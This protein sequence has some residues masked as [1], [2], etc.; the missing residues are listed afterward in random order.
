MDLSNLD[1]YADARP[2]VERVHDHS[3]D[4]F[5]ADHT[6]RPGSA[7]R[8]ATSAQA[9]VVARITGHKQG[10]VFGAHV[11]HDLPEWVQ[12][13]TPVTLDDAQLALPRPVDGVLDLAQ[14]DFVPAGPDTLNLSGEP[15]QH[16]VLP[17]GPLR[18][19]ID[20]LDTL[21][22]FVLGGTHLIVDAS[23]A[24]TA[25]DALGA[26]ALDV[27]EPDHVVALNVDALGQAERWHHVRA[28]STTFGWFYALRGAMAWVEHLREQG[29]HLVFLAQLPT[30]GDPSALE[31]APDPGARGNPTHRDIVEAIGARVVST[32]EGRC[33][34]ILHLPLSPLV[35]QAS[36]LMDTLSF[37]DVDAQI[38]VRPDGTYAPHYSTS[39]ASFPPEDPRHL[40]RKRA[41]RAFEA[42]LAVADKLAIFGPDE[43]E[44]EELELLELAKQYEG[45]VL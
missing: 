26:R 21:T 38:V 43:C 31:V 36:I 25:L 39:K 27:L 22:P 15:P 19:G 12:P 42:S 1:D 45:V 13:G 17:Q 5:V 32:A 24:Y 40:E 8:I 29:G 11:L 34:S 28:P 33:T 41:L 10:R 20:A 44:P 18:L 6:P 16:P 3:L 30:L 37:G 14:V 35:A 9:P 7:V 4:V 2:H 23:S